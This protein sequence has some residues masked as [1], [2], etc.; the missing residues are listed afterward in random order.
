MNKRAWN[1]ENKTYEQSKMLL[2]LYW[3]IIDLQKERVMQ[4]LLK[5]KMMLLHKIQRFLNEKKNYLHLQNL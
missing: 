2:I 3:A 4:M 1:N 5:H